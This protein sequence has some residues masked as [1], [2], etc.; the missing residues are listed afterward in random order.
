MPAPAGELAMATPAPRHCDML[1]VGAGI[2][3]LAAAEAIVRQQPEVDL[4]IVEAD[5]RP[6]GQIR[7]TVADGYTFEHGPTALTTRRPATG[8]LLER[9]GLVQYRAAA[10]RSYLYSNGALHAVPR[11]PREL[12][13]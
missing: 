8:L 5:R 6:G 3:G 10:G 12:A 13:S 1:V 9:L 4:M 2:A 7:T 11:T